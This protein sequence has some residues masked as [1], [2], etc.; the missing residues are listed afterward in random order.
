MASWI[1]D[2]PVPLYTSESNNINFNKSEYSG[3]STIVKNENEYVFI[4]YTDES[5]CCHYIISEKFERKDKMF[6]KIKIEN[7]KLEETY[8]EA[9]HFILGVKNSEIAN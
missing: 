7:Y 9:N 8:K 4:E 2:L 3:S 5:M 1:K 6:F